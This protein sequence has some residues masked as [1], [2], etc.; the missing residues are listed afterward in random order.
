M[1]RSLDIHFITPTIP[2]SYIIGSLTSE[3]VL[4]IRVFDPKKI[5]KT[6]GEESMY[7]GRNNS[8]KT[9]SEKLHGARMPSMLLL[10]ISFKRFRNFTQDLFFPC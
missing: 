6:E 5:D 1:I 8:R 10:P 4:F 7:L 2:V 9:H 3:E